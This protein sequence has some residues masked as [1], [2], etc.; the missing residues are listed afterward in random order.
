MFDLWVHLIPTT[1]QILLSDNK[2]VT[3]VLCRVRLLVPTL[4]FTILTRDSFLAQASPHF[5]FVYA[6][7][8]SVSLVPWMW[9]LGSFRNSTSATSL[10]TRTAFLSCCQVTKN[11]IR[12]PRNFIP[13]R[14]RPVLTTTQGEGTY[15]SSEGVKTQRKDIHWSPSLRLHCCIKNNVF[16]IATTYTL[17]SWQ[18]KL[19]EQMD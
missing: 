17:Y 11:V 18:Q 12:K 15:W 19:T 8:L 16:S 4:P 7:F 6:W 2:V 3:N 9:L 1:W 13:D 14:S 10:F 5:C